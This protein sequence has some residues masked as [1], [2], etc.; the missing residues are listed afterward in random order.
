[1]KRKICLALVPQID[2]RCRDGYRLQS[3]C[4]KQAFEALVVGLNGM[5]Y[6]N[7]TRIILSGGSHRTVT[8][9]EAREMEWIF[10][11]A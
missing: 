6:G 2:N 10:D 4:S 11:R 7:E 8:I 3:F 5:V 1:M 9:N